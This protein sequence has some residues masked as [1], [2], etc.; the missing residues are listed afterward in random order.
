MLNRIDGS[1]PCV[2]R[3]IQNQFMATMVN[4]S[5]S[6][7]TMRTCSI[8]QK[9]NRLWEGANFASANLEG[10]RRVWASM[11]TQCSCYLNTVLLASKVKTNVALADAASEYWPK[12]KN[13][14]KL[15]TGAQWSRAANKRQSVKRSGPYNVQWGPF[16]GGFTCLVIVGAS[17]SVWNIS[18]ICEMYIKK[19]KT[20]NTVD[21]WPPAD[22]HVSCEY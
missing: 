15:Q 5:R 9:A 16:G 19:R 14:N 7:G 13:N 12:K 3:P 4:I 17:I 8:E 1:S 10:N 18:N 2:A 6:A 22:A 11:S 20:S 21:D